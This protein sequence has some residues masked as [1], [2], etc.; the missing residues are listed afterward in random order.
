MRFSDQSHFTRMFKSIRG[1]SPGH[2]AILFKTFMIDYRYCKAKT[3]I[4]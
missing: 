4:I 1:I 2:F 3:E